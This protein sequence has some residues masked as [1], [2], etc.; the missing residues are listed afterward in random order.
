MM[1]LLNQ[2]EVVLDVGAFKI[3]HS[4][5]EWC[6]LTAHVGLRAEIHKIVIVDG[7]R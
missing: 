7:G 4:N 1:Q 2:H 6:K 3:N 5:I